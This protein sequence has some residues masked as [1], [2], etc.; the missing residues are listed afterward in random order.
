MAGTPPIA[1][2][3]NILGPAPEDVIEWVHDRA[4][5]PDTSQRRSCEIDRTPFGKWI[6][7]NRQQ[8]GLTQMEL[9]VKLDT[10]KNTI[11]RVERGGRFVSEEVLVKLEA[12]FGPMPNDVRNWTDERYR[13]NL[14]SRTHNTRVTRRSSCGSPTI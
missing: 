5:H 9:A 10:G 6:Y 13:Q 7:D 14:A 1:H 3:Q 2:I 4:L 11:A 12:L 8:L